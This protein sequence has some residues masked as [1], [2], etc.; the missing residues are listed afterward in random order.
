MPLLAIDNELDDL[1]APGPSSA[2][3][4]NRLAARVLRSLRHG[5][6]RDFVRIARSAPSVTTPLFETTLTWYGTSCEMRVARR[7][8]YVLK[9]LRRAAG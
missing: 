8:K 3:R 7:A 9:V 1:D 5:T 4:R 6:T 2:A